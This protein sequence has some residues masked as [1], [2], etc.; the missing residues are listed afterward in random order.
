MKTFL[1]ILSSTVALGLDFVQ[2]CM[3]LHALLSWF[4][5][6]SGEGGPIRRFIA[7]VTELFV[8]PVRAFLE[9]F[10]W[11]RRCPIDVSFMITFFLLAL[12]SVFLPQGRF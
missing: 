7:A 12:I 9:R 1:Y 8:A 10:E 4:P 11:V 3:F 6:A 5:P 2:I